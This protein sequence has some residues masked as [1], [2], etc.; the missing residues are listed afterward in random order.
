M[1]WASGE[2]WKAIEDGFIGLQF[3]DA[4]RHLATYPRPFCASCGASALHWIRSRGLGTVSACANLKSKR[5]FA[6]CILLVQL[7]EGV[8]V[9]AYGHGGLRVGD[10]VVAEFK[11]TDERSFPY[12]VHNTRGSVGE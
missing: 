4:C 11:R 8:R 9:M 1:T 10:S 2:Y 5:P 6:H 12:F 7:H 3:C